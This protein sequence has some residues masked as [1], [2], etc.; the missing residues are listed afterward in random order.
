MTGGLGPASVSTRSSN[1]IGRGSVATD[2]MNEYDD[3]AE[4]ADFDPAPPQ[5]QDDN[6]INGN[7]LDD[8]LSAHGSRRRG[9]SRSVSPYNRF[10]IEPSYQRGQSQVNIGL[11]ADYQRRFQ[12][13]NG[14][15]SEEEAMRRQRQASV[16][17]PPAPQQDADDEDLQRAIQASQRDHQAGDEQNEA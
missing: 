16:S 12:E 8:I 6:V 5:Y 14:P 13:Y 7:D 2:N 15:T 3:D 17:M 9:N 10:D 4:S 1:E 11:D